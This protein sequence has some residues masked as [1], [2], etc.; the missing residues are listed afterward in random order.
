MPWLPKKAAE[1]NVMFVLTKMEEDRIITLK[2]KK[3][4]RIISIKKKDK[5]YFI[6]ENGF[7]NEDYE[8][9]D[10]NNLKKVLKELIEFEFPR[11]HE[12]LLT[13]Q[14]EKD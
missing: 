12:I 14:K 4:D 3:K 8:V 2:S 7:K 10:D 11:S 1:K 13:N 5:T 6:H 9:P